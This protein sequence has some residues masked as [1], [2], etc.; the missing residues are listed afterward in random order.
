MWDGHT[1]AHIIRGKGIPTPPATN[2]GHFHEN[3]VELWIILEGTLD[4]LI[5]GEQLVTGTVGC[6]IGSP[7]RKE[8]RSEFREMSSNQAAL[9]VTL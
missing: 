8:T 9:V 1:A 5:E 6:I 3:M 2:L 7:T 4:F